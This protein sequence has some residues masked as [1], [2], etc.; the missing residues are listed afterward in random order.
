[1]LTTLGGE[2]LGD[3]PLASSFGDLA[4]QNG[5][6]SDTKREQKHEE[7]RLLRQYEKN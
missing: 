6:F 7:S 4:L 2:S 5:I 1:M 3:L